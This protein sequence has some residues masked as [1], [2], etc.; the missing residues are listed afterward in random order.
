MATK[1]QYHAPIQSW[2]ERAGKKNVSSVVNQVFMVNLCRYH[3]S[4]AR[5]QL[6]L[7]VILPSILLEL[8]NAKPIF[9]SFGKE[10]VSPSL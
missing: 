4:T 10:T 6:I 5:N 2:S 1:Y 9:L 8:P 7:L 3:G